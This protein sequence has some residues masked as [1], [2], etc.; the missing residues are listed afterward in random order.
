MAL[1]DSLTAGYGLPHDQG[2]V[3]QLQKAIDAEKL[4]AKVLDDGVSGDTSADALARLDWALGDTPKAG[5]NA[6]I[7][8]LGGNDGLRG[9]PPADMER[10]IAAILDTLKARHIPVLLSGMVA[11]PNMGPAYSAAF[12]A[13]FTRLLGRPGLI[14]DPFFLQG[15]ALHENL[16]QA[17]HMHPNAAGVKIIVAR[18]M[19]DVRRLIARARRE[20]PP[21]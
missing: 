15:V 12:H 6:A 21:A 11:P 4:D 2:L 8:E 13:V 14:A 17:D 7:I 3:V 18:L 10:N 1:G 5:P 16:E 20:A 19:P 9:L